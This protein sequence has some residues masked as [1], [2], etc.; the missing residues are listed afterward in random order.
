MAQHF[1]EF[2]VYSVP[3]LLDRES[4]GDSPDMV[5][6]AWA[7]GPPPFSRHFHWRHSW[8]A[9]DRLVFS[10]LFSPPCLGFHSPSLCM[11]SAGHATSPR[12]PFLPAA[13]ESVVAWSCLRWEWDKSV[14]GSPPL[15][16]ENRNPGI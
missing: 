4:K 6:T 11:L 5:T 9:R 16:G 14:Y 8:I 15:P 10:S 7:R 12:F 13:L 1:H 2:L 3:F